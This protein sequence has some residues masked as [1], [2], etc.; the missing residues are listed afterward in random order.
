MANWTAP[1]D[2]LGAFCRDNHASLKGNGAGALAGLTFA[3]K[4]AFHIAGTRTGFGQP[5][6]LRTH[7]APRETA[8]AVTKLLAAGADM[9]AKTHCDELCYSLTGENV[10]FGT[11]VNVNAPGRVP[12]GS[13]NGS[14][15]AVAGGL[16]DFALGTDCGGSIR[17]PA[18]Y[19]GIIGLRPTHGRVSDDGVLPFGPSFDVVGWFSRDPLVFVDVANVLLDEDRAPPPTR[20]IVAEDAWA[21]LEAPVADALRPAAEKAKAVLGTTSVRVSPE[22]LADWFEVFRTLQAAEIW[23]TLG[24]WVTEAKPQLGPGVKERFAYAATIT[25]DQVAAASARRRAITAHVE[26]ILGD[27]GVI[28]LPTSPRVAPLRGTPADQV[29]VEYRN[30]AMRLLCIAGLCGLPQISLPMAKI[31]GLPLGLSLIGARNSDRGLIALAKKILN[32]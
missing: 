32:S 16:V 7:D 27:D 21:L 22:G 8:A 30:Q 28:C 19:C 18:S 29:E 26:S 13:S 9:V 17:I 31:D 20:L 5:D 3:V 6:W 11:P 14:A 1:D 24:A 12:G 2:P 15:A 23:A 4:D 10:H 25:R